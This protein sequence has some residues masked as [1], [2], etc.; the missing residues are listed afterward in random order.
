MPGVG[1]CCN[2][3]LQ[4]WEWPWNWAVG[5]S[6]KNFET[7]HRKCLDFLELSV[8]ENVNGNRSAIEDT[9]GSEEACRENIY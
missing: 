8:S 5:R 7:H 4:K 6:W 3:Y 1:C 9:G 2:E